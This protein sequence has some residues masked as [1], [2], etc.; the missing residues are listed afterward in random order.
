LSTNLWNW[1]FECSSMMSCVTS[2]NDE[3]MLRGKRWRK[4]TLANYTICFLW[5]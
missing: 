1:Y 3:D 4:L 5:L 2:S